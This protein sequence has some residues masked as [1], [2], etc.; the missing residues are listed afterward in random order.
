MSLWPQVTIFLLHAKDEYVLINNK[1]LESSK[2]NTPSYVKAKLFLSSTNDCRPIE[3]ESFIKHTV[4][5]PQSNGNPP[6]PTTHAFVICKWLKY[7]PEHHCIGKQAQV[8]ITAGHTLE[9]A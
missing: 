9:L 5:V 4:Q 7:H 8:C 2:K 1:K 3:V 6:K